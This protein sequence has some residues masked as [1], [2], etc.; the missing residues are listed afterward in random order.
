M[1][2]KNVWQII[3]RGWKEGENKDISKI[4]KKGSCPFHSLKN[5]VFMKCSSKRESNN[6]GLDVDD[7][8]LLLDNLRNIVRGNLIKSKQGEENEKPRLHLPE[9]NESSNK[10]ICYLFDNSTPHTSVDNCTTCK[11][12]ILTEY[13]SFA[14]VTFWCN[15]STFLDRR[16]AFLRF[17][18]S[19]L[20]LCI[21]NVFLC[22]KNAVE[23]CV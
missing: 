21:K 18:F 4:Y 8:D 10:Y 6:I 23:N 3:R 9:P 13:Y 17:R 1:K 7:L 19:L 11:E 12:N 22:H 14:S 16:N 20:D 15:S 2:K 5:A